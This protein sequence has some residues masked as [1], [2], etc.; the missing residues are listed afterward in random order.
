[1]WREPCAVN[2]N[3]C[4]PAVD[5]DW[6]AS[7][8][9][10]VVRA[11]VL[12]HHTLLFARATATDALPPQ[13]F[14]GRPLCMNQYKRVFWECRIPGDPIDS[15][16]N[17]ADERPR[18]ITVMCR[19]HAFAITALDES[20]YPLSVHD[21][22]H[23]LI[24]VVR[25]AADLPPAEG[26]GIL[27][28]QNRSVWAAAREKLIALS[29]DNERSLV[30]IQ[31]SAFL[32]VLDDA[33]AADDEEVCATLCMAGNGENRWYDKAYTL[34]V[35][36]DGSSGINGEHS[37]AD[38]MIWVHCTNYVRDSIVRTLASGRLDMDT[39]P[40]RCPNGP[41]APQHLPLVADSGIRATIA[42]ARASYAQLAGRIELRYAAAVSAT[43]L[44]TFCW[45]PHKRRL[46]HAY[47]VG[48]DIIKVCDDVCDGVCVMVIA[49]SE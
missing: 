31:R 2:V 18:H 36:R 6:P 28:A 38:A 7:A 4:G 12:V 1:M 35:F 23:Q 44:L 3:F 48:K 41:P 15:Q 24:Q 27:T 29:P 14:A 10:Q 45:P 5:T 25:L 33:D 11:A 37:P 16:A 8:A 42:A 49:H 21:I 26:V 39:A 20:G 46:L 43:L 40:T 9:T 19:H 34:V 17:Y 47:D 30:S 22:E 13:S 32:L